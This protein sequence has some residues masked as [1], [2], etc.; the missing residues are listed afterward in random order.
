MKHKRQGTVWTIL[1]GVLFLIAGSGV[2]I[3]AAVSG[4]QE[5]ARAER[6]AATTYAALTNSSIGR[7]VLIEG[8]ISTKN[9]VKTRAYVAFIREEVTGRSTDNKR[10]WSERERVMPPLLLDLP[11][12]AVRIAN[13]SYEFGP[14]SV[15][16]DGNQR[17]RGLIINQPVV[18]V[19]MLTQTEDGVAITADTI[20]PG[21]RA[22]YIAGLRRFRTGF[23]MFG[24]V[25][26]IV[27]AAMLVYARR[28]VQHRQ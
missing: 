13:D 11:D 2:A 26:A 6:L 14:I 5:I 17:F 19:G 9:P 23:T 16:E 28:A 24:A 7:E 25:F 21:T 20:A 27:G 12:G 8:K 4:T 18:A 3:L 1:I 10:N 22:E 15:S